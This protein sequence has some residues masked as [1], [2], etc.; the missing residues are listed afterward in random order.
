MYKCFESI[1]ATVRQQAFSLI[2]SNPSLSPKHVLWA[3]IAGKTHCPLGVVN[4]VLADT[5]EPRRTQYCFTADQIYGPVF[6][7]PGNGE[8]EMEILALFG[9][10]ENPDLLDG[11]INDID[12][13]KIKTLA[14]LAT[15]MG[16]SE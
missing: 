9:I 8:S 16:V 12:G 15:A 14:E 6:R 11:F 7:I 2:A 3:E 1:P 10:Q 13:G 5:E 4:K